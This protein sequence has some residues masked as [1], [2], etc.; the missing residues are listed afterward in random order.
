MVETYANSLQSTIWWSIQ[1]SISE[2]TISRNPGSILTTNES[3]NPLLVPGTLQPFQVALIRVGKKT[4]S[5]FKVDH[6]SNA[7]GQ[8]G[9]KESSKAEHVANVSCI[10]NGSQVV[11]NQILTRTSTCSDDTDVDTLLQIPLYLTCTLR[12]VGF[13]K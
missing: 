3:Y 4:A 1:V 6:G 5:I 12:K 10:T 8:S 9:G 7:G 2:A 13:T 11:K